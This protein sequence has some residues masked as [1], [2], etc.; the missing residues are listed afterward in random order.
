[1]KPHRETVDHRASLF[2]NA[3]PGCHGRK[4]PGNSFCP[5]CYF[6]LDRH[7]RNELYK[8]IGN[9]YEQAFADALQSID[10]LSRYPH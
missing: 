5:R 4:N 7:Q 9:G 8:P 2:S 3:C 1:M 6:K 10:S